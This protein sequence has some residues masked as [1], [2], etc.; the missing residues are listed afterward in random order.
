MYESKY[1]HKHAERR[2]RLFPEKVEVKTKEISHS[3]DPFAYFGVH[4]PL[5]RQQQLSSLAAQQQAQ[6]HNSLGGLSSL[7]GA[8]GSLLHPANF[9]RMR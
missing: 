1:K 9:G 5:R 8:A 7:L 2:A 4:D 3:D 6:Q